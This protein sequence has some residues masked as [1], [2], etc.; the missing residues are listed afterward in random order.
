[1][2]SLFVIALLLAAGSG[3]PARV[4]G[5]EPAKPAV[6]SY[7][8]GI[9]PYFTADK[10]FQLYN[11]F[12]LYL[13]ENTPD[14]WELKLGK[15]HDELVGG[16]C[17]GEI[18]IAYLGPVPFGKALKACDARP[19][20]L[21]LGADG[22]PFYRSVIVTTD[23]RIISLRDLRGKKFALFEKSTA[24]YYLPLKMLA[25]EG[26]ARQDVDPVLF[27]SQDK[28]VTALLAGEI[29]AGGLKESLYEKFKGAGLRALKFS[30]PL[31]Q[32]VYA[33]GPRLPPEAATAL[34]AALLKVQPLG[35]E[36]D[37]ELVRYWDPELAFGFAAPAAGFTDDVLKLLR[38]LDPFLK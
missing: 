32:F 17:A 20:L 14:R 27:V 13:N 11:P 16:L 18:D 1:M 2:N 23:P 19:L 36:A 5:A 30:K 22:K 26:L 8:I 34:T 21:S 10:I 4:R 28:I 15:T 31:P 9:V 38:S 33:A 29:A 24:S 7:I 35:R 12:I 37:R 3:L 25:D 6:P